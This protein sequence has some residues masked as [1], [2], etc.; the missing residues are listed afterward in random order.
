[1]LLFRLRDFAKIAIRQTETEMI[2]FSIYTEHN[3]IDFLLY[4]GRFPFLREGDA[5]VQSSQNLKRRK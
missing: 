2:S 4:F 3:K 1:M 5:W